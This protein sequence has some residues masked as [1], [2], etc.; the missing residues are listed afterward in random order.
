MRKFFL[1]IAA[2]CC[3]VNIL[4]D[5][6]SGSCGENLTW[7][8]DSYN[9]KLTISG[10]GAMTDFEPG[11]AP[12]YKYHA[13]IEKIYLYQKNNEGYSSNPTYVGNNA[14]KDF[15][16][17]SDIY[18]PPFP[19]RLSNNAFDVYSGAKPQVHVLAN[20]ESLYQNAVG[21]KDFDMVLPKYYDE[22]REDLVSSG[23]I[24]SWS[25]IMGEVEGIAYAGYSSNYNDNAIHMGIPFIDG[26]TYAGDVVIPESITCSGTNLE[27]QEIFP[28]A[29]LSSS[30]KS[31][32]LPSTLW[33]ISEN[34]FRGCSSL[35]RIVCRA[36][37]PPVFYIELGSDWEEMK[38]AT[39]EIFQG[40][41]RDIRVYVP[42]EAIE[43]YRDTNSWG[44]YFTN[45]LPLSQMHEAIESPS[46]QGRSGEATKTIR[47]GQL[48]IE[49]NGKTYNAQG[50]QVK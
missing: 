48:F 2:L 44:N 7:A 8:Y 27:I 16:A 4:A 11:S 45:I 1:F 36:A 39:S 29:F 3:A 22:W 23:F 38:E 33:R 26:F 13:V 12:W 30:M 6:T 50:A 10:S 5:A 21:W 25:F 47:N 42:D 28:K 19:P 43:D 20:C 40:V 41:S 31:I 18:C 37:V 34:A 17:L 14:F 35:E 46:L 49:L 32:V 24:Y 9:Q 15:S